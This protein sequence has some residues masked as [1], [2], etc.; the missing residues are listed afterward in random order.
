MNDIQIKYFIAV[1][2]NNINFT[3]AANAVYISQPALSKQI[4]KFEKELGVELFDRE[5]AFGHKAHPGRSVPV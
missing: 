2:K 1:V 3:K 5:N 4:A